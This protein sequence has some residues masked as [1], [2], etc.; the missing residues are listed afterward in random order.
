MQPAAG[1]VQEMEA[2]AINSTKYPELQSAIIT[3]I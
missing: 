3:E 1:Q 2:F